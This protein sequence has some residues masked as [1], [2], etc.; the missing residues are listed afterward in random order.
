MTTKPA[1]AAA[2]P[3]PAAATTHRGALVDSRRR[4][5]GRKAADWV[6]RS[7]VR[8]L[9]VIALLVGVPVTVFGQVLADN[10]RADFREAALGRV[11]RGAAAGA[12]LVA[13]RVNTVMVRNGS[14]TSTTAFRTLVADGD[15]KGLE[16]LL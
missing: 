15:A 13:D 16:S 2:H 14:I 11:S 9:V 10:A 5:R 8:M 1:T 7:P 12:S 3:R 6:L 4:S